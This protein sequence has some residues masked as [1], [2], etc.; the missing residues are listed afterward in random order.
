MQIDPRK[1]KRESQRKMGINNS[2]VAVQWNTM[3]FK[4]ADPPFSSPS[5]P[6]LWI[7]NTRPPSILLDKSLA[8][9]TRSRGS[10][11]LFLCSDRRFQ[12]IDSYKSVAF[13][14]PGS[15]PRPPE[16]QSCLQTVVFYTESSSTGSKA[17]IDSAD[18]A[19]RRQLTPEPWSW[20]WVA[21]RA[22]RGR[23]LP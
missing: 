20:L 1:R 12:A 10:L 13:F 8:N 15:N 9:M 4:A 11:E 23:G 14:P 2:I 16:W 22:R 5:I 7:S 6:C 19:L 18:G 17:F 3:L 21:G